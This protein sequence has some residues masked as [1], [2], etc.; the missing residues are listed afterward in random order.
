MRWILA[1]EKERWTKKNFA[2]FKKKSQTKDET[3]DIQI[4]NVL[5]SVREKVTSAEFAYPEEEMQKTYSAKKNIKSKFLWGLRKKLTYVQKILVLLL[6]LKSS[7][8]NIRNILFPEPQLTPGRRSAM[9]VT[10][11]LS[12]ELENQTC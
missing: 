12:R 9:M 11:P 4:T 8:L 7:Q 10:G 1:W 6:H 2:Y 3:E 5:T